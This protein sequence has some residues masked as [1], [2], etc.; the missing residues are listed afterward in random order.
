MLSILYWIII[1]WFYSDMYLNI[2]VK[3]TVRKT[4][5]VNIS[6]A[7]TWICVH[8][9]YYY[10]SGCIIIIHPVYRNRQFIISC[11]I[12][13]CNNTVNYVQIIHSCS[14]SVTKVVLTIKVNL[15]LTKQL[16][17]NLSIFLWSCTWKTLI[18]SRLLNSDYTRIV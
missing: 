6:I 12:E 3:R 16:E 9:L 7:L 10:T 17:I 8:R 14:I 18:K 1:I 4:R 15:T 11:C 13:L 2:I 5:T